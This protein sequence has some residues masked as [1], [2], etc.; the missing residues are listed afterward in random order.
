MELTPDLLAGEQVLDMG[1][2]GGAFVSETTDPVILPQPYSSPSDFAAQYPTPLDP[3]EVISM[4]EEVSLWQAIPEE[5]TSLQAYTWRELNTL[6]F[7]SGSALV[8][9]HNIWDFPELGIPIK[10]ACAEPS[11]DTW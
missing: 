7:T 5:M 11:L 8:S 9:V 3:M 10:I 6:A 4:C 1:R 2:P